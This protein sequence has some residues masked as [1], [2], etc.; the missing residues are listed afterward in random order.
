M[1]FKNVKN[2]HKWIVLSS[3]VAMAA[4]LLGSSYYS[5]PEFSESEWSAVRLPTNL[6]QLRSLHSVVSKYTHSNGL[7]VYYAYVS[8]YTVLQV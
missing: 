6:D 4:I 5:L 3:L 7:A 2:Q 8:L 1:P